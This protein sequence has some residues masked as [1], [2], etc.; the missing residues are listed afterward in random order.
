M[1]S[2]LPKSIV[3]LFPTNMPKYRSTHEENLNWL[4][5]YSQQ[6]F[7]PSIFYK[8]PILF[9]TEHN[10]A[11][12]TPSSLFSINIYKKSVSNELIKLQSS[13]DENIWPIFLF[14]SLPGLRKSSREGRAPTNYNDTTETTNDNNH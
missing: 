13:G 6:V 8:G 2:K 3:G 12:K 4:Q 1:P 14:H 5:T 9:I 7:P 11:M 10:I